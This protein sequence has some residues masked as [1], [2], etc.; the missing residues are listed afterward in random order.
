M[1]KLFSL[2]ETFSQQKIFAL[3]AAFVSAC[4]LLIYYNQFWIAPDEGVFAHFADRILAGEVYGVDF[5][6]LQPGL[7]AYLNAFLFEV[8][9]RDLLSLRYPLVVMNVF[10]SGFVALMLR[11]YGVLSSISGLIATTAFGFVIYLNP[12]PNWYVVYFSFY[13]MALFSL[14]DKQKLWRYFVIGA[15]VGL[16]LCFRHPSGAF[17]GAGVLAY[18]VY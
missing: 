11:H 5:D 17:L 14:V 8:F 3:F 13:V 2:L 6:G 16:S 9:G 15:L 7:H 1:Q 12:S 4:F 10:A 18:L